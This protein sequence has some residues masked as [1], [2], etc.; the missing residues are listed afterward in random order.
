M[1]SV[2]VVGYPT[3]VRKNILN[4]LV[5]RK[6]NRKRDIYVQTK[7]FNEKKSLDIRKLE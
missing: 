3:H 5:R 7:V 2:V 4:Q 6:T 1:R